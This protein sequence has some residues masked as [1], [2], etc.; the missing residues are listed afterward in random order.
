ME[1]RSTTTTIAIESP[2]EISWSSSSHFNLH[3]MSYYKRLMLNVKGLDEPIP[4]ATR[5]WARRQENKKQ[6][7]WSS[8]VFQFFINFIIFST[9]NYTAA[10]P[11]YPRI[12]SRAHSI[13]TWVLN[14]EASRRWTNLVHIQCKPTRR[15]LVTLLFLVVRPSFQIISTL[16]LDRWLEPP[17]RM[18]FVWGWLKKCSALHI[19]LGCLTYICSLGHMDIDHNRVS[20]VG[21]TVHSRPRTQCL[22]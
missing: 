16:W 20:K 12:Y 8:T 21:D 22:P 18:R 7:W 1:V 10:R 3:I 14:Y 6:T 9:K 11:C 17:Q 15:D 4:I 13:S 5:C 2:E 19:F